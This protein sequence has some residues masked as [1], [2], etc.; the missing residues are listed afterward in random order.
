MCREANDAKTCIN[1]VQGQEAIYPRVSVRYAEGQALLRQQFSVNEVDVAVRYYW[2]RQ[3][4]PYEQ[5]EVS[6]RK[7]PARESSG[8]AIK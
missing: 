6:P 5:I 3:L 7:T 8:M 4:K 1:L 2:S